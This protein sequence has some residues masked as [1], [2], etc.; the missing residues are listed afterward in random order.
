MSSNK[1]KPPSSQGKATAATSSNDVNDIITGNNQWEED[2]AFQYEEIAFDPEDEEN[3]DDMLD[4]FSA[5]QQQLSAPGSPT[6]NNGAIATTTTVVTHVRPSVVDDFIRNFLIKSGMK[7]SLEVFN[8]EWY[9]LQSKGRLPAELS[10]PIPDIYLRNEELDQQTRQVKRKMI[11]LLFLIILL[12]AFCVW[13]NIDM[14]WRYR[15]VCPVQS[16][17]RRNC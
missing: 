15:F 14:M 13:N 6:R 4:A 5:L 17:R 2:D 7:R 10:T 8:T 1:Q 11:L 16:I 3:E 9:E 12:L